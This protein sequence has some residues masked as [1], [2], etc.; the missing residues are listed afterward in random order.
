MFYQRQVIMV[1]LHEKKTKQTK[2]HTW[3]DMLS[4]L[5]N[6]E[7][8]LKLFHCAWSQSAP[9]FLV[10]VSLREKFCLFP[11]EHKHMCACTPEIHAYLLNLLLCEQC[12]SLS[13]HD[14][15]WKY[16]DWVLEKDEEL[17]VKVCLLQ[18]F[19]L[20]DIIDLVIG[21]FFYSCFNDWRKQLDRKIK[22]RS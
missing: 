22:D 10:L 18:P 6:F 8:M 19:W 11:W 4:N 9:S 7:E 12:F 16:I 5:A 3:M 20:I 21:F 15:V 1:K 14:L 2:T 13:D 17:G